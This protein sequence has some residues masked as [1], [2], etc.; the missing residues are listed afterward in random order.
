MARPLPKNWYVNAQKIG[1]REDLEKRDDLK[2]R[3]SYFYTKFVSWCAVQR[4]TYENDI[5]DEV[6]EFEERFI[7]KRLYNIDIKLWKKI[8]RQIFER[9]NFTCS[10]CGKVGGILE[11]DHIIPIS[12]NGTNNLSNLTTAC[13]KCNRQKKDKSV[14]EFEEWRGLI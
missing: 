2:T 5:D 9:D 14:K 12:K 10:Y 1:I 3:L 13:R 4:V 7:K 11:V 6:D 8:S